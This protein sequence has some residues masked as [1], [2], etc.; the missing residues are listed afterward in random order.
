MFI[1]I[2]GN[3]FHSKFYIL[4]NLP[5][6]FILGIPFLSQHKATITFDEHNQV[7]FY[8]KQPV[9]A[10]SN[11][12]ISP[13]SE[14]LCKGVMYPE[15]VQYSSWCQGECN[16]PLSHSINGL[17]IANTAVSVHN[18]HIPVRI[19]NYT[20][21]P[22]SI[23]SGQLIAQ[24]QPWRPEVQLS[25]FS[26]APIQINDLADNNNDSFIPDIDLSSSIL[27]QTQQNTLRQL[28]SKHSDCFVDPNDN[29]IGQTNITQHE[30]KLIPGAKPIHK[31]PYRISPEKR[32]AMNELISD[33]VRQGIIEQV[34]DGE[35][36][37]PALLVRK[38]SGG[39]R[40][41][42]DY[43]GLNAQT[44]TLNLRIP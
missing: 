2:D 6:P 26:L 21:H 4:H 33:H 24:F 36:A 42:V 23:T 38:S 27:N 14:Y 19:F 20:Q 28:L 8:F 30:I 1:N 40:M 31:M 18:N 15:S 43:R 41:V 17:I 35:W 44:E 32:Q 34:Y 12:T 3:R 39:H 22:I 9:Y 13:M 16:P 37:S 7:H 10:V 25:D 29:T 11:V 5:Y